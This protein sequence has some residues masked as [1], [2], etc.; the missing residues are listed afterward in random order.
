MIIEAM[1]KIWFYNPDLYSV[2]DC[3][4][5]G[6]GWD[7]WKARYLKR[8]DSGVRKGVVGCL[9][10]GLRGGGVMESLLWEYVM[11]HANRDLGMTGAQVREGGGEAKRRADNAIH[12]R[13]AASVLI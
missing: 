1:K 5:G 11:T 9:E 4:G 3:Y 12:D 7:F 6:G 13:S 2:K 10:E 8:D